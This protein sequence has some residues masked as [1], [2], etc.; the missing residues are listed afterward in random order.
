M[1]RHFMNETNSLAASIIESE[2]VV[3][4]ANNNSSNDLKERPVKGDFQSIGVWFSSSEKYAK[5]FGKN[6]HTHPIPKGKFL[7]PKDHAFKS[8]FF[9]K[10]IAAKLYGKRVGALLVKYAKAWPKSPRGQSYWRDEDDDFMN[11]GFEDEL[12]NYGIKFK[13]SPSGPEP[14]RQLIY[15]NVDY[16]QLLK[17]K[18]EAKYDGIFFKNSKIDRHNHD[19][20]L[21]FKPGK[22]KNWKV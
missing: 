15:S 3:Y 11:E 4:H 1:Y 14:F 10:E 7:K 18:L 8:V 5:M 19:V 2:G 12:E 16:V 9:D 21:I 6:I 17:W 22:I 13:G 20:Y